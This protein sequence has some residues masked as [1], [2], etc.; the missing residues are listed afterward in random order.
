VTV[1]YSHSLCLEFV[2]ASHFP[3][4]HYHYLLLLFLTVFFRLSIIANTL[5]SLLFLLAA[6]SKV[7]HLLL[8]V[9]PQLWSWVSLLPQ[10]D[11]TV[12]SIFI[13][14]NLSAH[15]LV[16]VVSVHIVVQWAE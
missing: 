10:V 4:H 6:I 14:Q 9:V 1:L 5:L 16:F 2:V 15:R 12:V 8:T 7:L 11:I 13:L 3:H